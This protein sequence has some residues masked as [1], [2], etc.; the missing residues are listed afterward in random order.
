MKPRNALLFSLVLASTSAL[1]QPG[2]KSGGDDRWNI[3]GPA[4][5]S[6]E[7]G[8]VGFSVTHGL[9]YSAWRKPC[10]V[11]I[12]VC[13]YEKLTMNYPADPDVPCERMMPPSAGA[14]DGLQRTY[15]QALGLV[16]ACPSAAPGSAPPGCLRPRAPRAPRCVAWPRMARPGASLVEDLARLGGKFAADVLGLGEQLVQHARIEHLRDGE[17]VLAFH[18]RR[19]R[20]LES[21]SAPASAARRRGWR[22][23]PKARARTCAAPQLGQDRSLR[24]CCEA[25]SAAEPNQPSKRW[26]ARAKQVENNHLDDSTMR[27]WAATATIP[28]AIER[29]GRARSRAPRRLHRSGGLPARDGAPLVAHLDLRRPREPGAERRRLHHARHRRASR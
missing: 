1:A 17:R 8:H 16:Q 13:E 11:P 5:Y 26:P 4:W 7:C 22:A 18:L 27:R 20:R 24:S 25:K 28:T 15:L 29:P 14:G 12:R 10:S 19:L 9:P 21:A 2:N 23:S 6:T 3:T